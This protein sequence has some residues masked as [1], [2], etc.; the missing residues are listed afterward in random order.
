MSPV[1][2]WKKYLKMMKKKFCNNEIQKINK[3]VTRYFSKKQELKNK[4]I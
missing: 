1:I 4:I 3:K 2:I